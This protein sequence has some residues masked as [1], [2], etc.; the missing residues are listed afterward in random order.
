MHKQRASV[1]RRC[2]TAQPFGRCAAVT[3]WAVRHRTMVN[4]VEWSGQ[5]DGDQTRHCDRAARILTMPLITI[6]DADR[7]H[8]LQPLHRATGYVRHLASPAACCCSVVLTR[9]VHS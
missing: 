3:R 6:T 4:T 8:V 9:R 7:D 2:V 5:D 1:S